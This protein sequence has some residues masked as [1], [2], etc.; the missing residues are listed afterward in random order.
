MMLTLNE[1]EQKM[2]AEILAVRLRE[3]LVEVRHTD[4]REFKARLKHEEQMLERLKE[5]LASA[6]AGSEAGS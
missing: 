5:R 6:T 3:L 2:L 4:N 1:E